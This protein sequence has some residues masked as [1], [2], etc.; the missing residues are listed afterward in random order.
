MDSSMADGIATRQVP[1]FS[2]ISCAALT[3]LPPLLL[4][5]FWPP[6]I[7]GEPSKDSLSS[8]LPQW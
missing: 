4:A 8:L 2:V 7:H 3:E 1:E 5:T 6:A